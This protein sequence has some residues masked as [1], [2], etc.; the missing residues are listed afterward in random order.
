MFLYVMF[1][2]KLYTYN[3]IID[4]RPKALKYGGMFVGQLYENWYQQSSM[5]PYQALAPTQ[6]IAPNPVM[7]YVYQPQPPPP[8]MG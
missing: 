3:I 5:M 7:G 6:G 1:L 4:H 2:Y 8:G